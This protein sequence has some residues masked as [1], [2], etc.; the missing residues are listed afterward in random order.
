MQE[1][2][3]HWI[4]SKELCNLKKNRLKQTFEQKTINYVSL[5]S[6]ILTFNYFLTRL[7]KTFR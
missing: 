2:L 3:K 1:Y 7:L 5:Q 4:D 6:K